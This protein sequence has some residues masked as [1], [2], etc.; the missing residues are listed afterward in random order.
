MLNRSD[1]APRAYG[2]AI[3]FRLALAA[4]GLLVLP[5]AAWP[6]GGADVT[7]EN[8]TLK[9][10]DG[11]AFSAPRVDFA[12]TNLSKDEIAALLSPDTPEADERALVKKLKA[13]RISV[14]TIEI[15]GKD[16]SRVHLHDLVATD[17]DA[18]RVAKLQFAAL[19]GSGTS[20]GSPVSIKSGALV[21][22]GLDL[23]DV[24]KAVGGPGHG[25]QKGRLDHLAW[26]AIDVVT[27]DASAK[28]MHIAVGSVEVHS[29][30]SGDAL[31]EGWTKLTGVV[32]EPSP[33]SEEGKDLASLG[34]SR[35]ELA[36]GVSADYKAEA[37]T[38]SLD[39]LTVEGAQMGSIA[40]KANFS[41][42]PAQLFAP[43]NE[44]RLQALFD[45]G[46]A[47]MEVRLVN[48]GLFEKAVA[49]F[50]KQEGATPDALKHQ[51]SAAIGQMAP[52]FLGADPSALKA[53]AEAQKFIASPHNLT[54]SIK[55][56]NGSLKATDF[57]AIGDPAAFTGKLD[58][59]AAANQ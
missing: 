15:A 3:A 28:A 55:A 4:S 54:V 51:W 19:E 31:K 56:K 32:I 52:M 7:I 22:D 29:G 34:Y 35:I 45:C 21:V 46:V 9:S 42:V 50:A 13:D 5:T 11:D 14:P 48:S 24:L 47:S 37:K 38:F 41:D 10:A 8:V 43:D 6:L 53:T 27:Q 58:I 16:G 23:A 57:M 1:R 26:S 44:G 25:R 12:N 18:G 17:V 20:D 33:D 59:A 40:L 30:Y 39:N 36:V 49:L 2:G